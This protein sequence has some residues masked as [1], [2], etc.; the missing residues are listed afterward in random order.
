MP[1]K[2]VGMT[3]VSRVQTLTFT[4]DDFAKDTHFTMY[5]MR[6]YGINSACTILK[7]S[8]IIIKT[9]A[10]AMEHWI[11]LLTGILLVD[12]VIFELY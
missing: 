9:P 12:A 1:L 8:P 4:F 7:T 2:A 3:L 11:N 5:V 6:I 10:E